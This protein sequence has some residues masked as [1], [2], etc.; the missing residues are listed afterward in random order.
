MFSVREIYL[1]KRSLG[2]FIF[3]TGYRAKELEKKLQE[4]NNKNDKSLEK[5]MNEHKQM[6]DELIILKDKI[7]QALKTHDKKGIYLK[8]KCQPKG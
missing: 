5:G 1:L 4:E 3:Y 6:R 2:N 8:K 7:K